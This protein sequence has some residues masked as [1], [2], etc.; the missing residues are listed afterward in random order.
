[1]SGLPDKLRP[2]VAPQP[3]PRRRSIRASFMAG[4]SGSKQP[5]PQPAVAAQPAEC[6]NRQVIKGFVVGHQLQVVVL[7]P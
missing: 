3:V 2:A 7:P 5:T 4:G 1:M 6:L